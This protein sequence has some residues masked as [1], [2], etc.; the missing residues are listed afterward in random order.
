MTA[1]TRWSMPRLIGAVVLGV[2][3]FIA[4]AIAA[5]LL[6]HTWRPAPPPLQQGGALPSGTGT[7]WQIRLDGAGGSAVFGLDL[8]RSTL[9]DAASRWPG[10]ALQVA[11]VRSPAG[12]L[13]LEAY[14]ESIQASGVNGKLL[15]GVTLPADVAQRWAER[16]T[17][18]TPLASGAH[19]LGLH[20]DDATQAQARMIDSLLFL[21][22]ARLDEATLAERFGAPAERLATADGLVHLLYPDRGLA[23]SLAD[24]GRQ[25]TVLQYVAPRDFARLRAPLLAA[26]TPPAPINH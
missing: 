1:E 19:R 2:L 26:L 20:H 18:D 5:P 12:E 23:I 4:L 9:A 21:P 10:E 22:A 13:S 24:S 16:A 11:L 7:P 8:G 14:L 6:W 17:R 15:L 3:A 25:R